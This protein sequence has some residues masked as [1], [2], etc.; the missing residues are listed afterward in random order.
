MPWGT[1]VILGF[2][3]LLVWAVVAR[4]LLQNPREDVETGIVWH[5]IRI[6]SRIF[7]RPRITGAENIPRSR[8]PGP[9]IVVVNHASGVDPVLVQ[10]ACPFEIR[11]VMAEDM[12]HP[13]GEWIWRWTRTIFVNR[14]GG[15]ISGTREALRHLRAGGVLGIFPEGGIERPSGRILPFLPGVGFIIRQSGA[16]VLPVLVQGVPS[17][18]PAWAALYRFSRARLTFMPIMDATAFDDDPDRIAQELHRLYVEWTGWSA[19]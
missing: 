16:P 10:A 3:V 4:R 18:E 15:E 12:R 9:L 6:Y 2:A 14:A 7:H 5:T 19:D 8:H 17:V 1:W 11:W 13:L